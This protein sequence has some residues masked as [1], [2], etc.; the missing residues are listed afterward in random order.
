M[1]PV[2]HTSC[3]PKRL[4]DFGRWGFF[5]SIE[6]ELDMIP[7]NPVDACAVLISVLLLVEFIKRI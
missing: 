5:T 3:K 2:M 1:L 6:K 4:T 7:L